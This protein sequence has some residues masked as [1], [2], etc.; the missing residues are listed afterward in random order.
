MKYRIL[1]PGVLAVFIL[2]SCN[3]NKPVPA[4]DIDMKAFFKN[5]EKDEF[6]ISPDGQYYSYLADYKGKSNVFV[7]NITSG[8]VSR[9]TNDT[10]RTIEGYFWKGSRI[11]Y[12]QDAMGDENFHFFSVKP[13]GADFK[14]LTPFAGVQARLLDEM[15]DVPGRE[16]DIVISLNKRDKEHPDPYLLNIETGE[17]T[18]LY[19]NRNNFY[20]WKTDNRGV[21]RIAVKS[22]GSNNSYYYRN[23]DRDT[24]SLLFEISFK[25]TFEP[26]YFDSTDKIIYARSNIGRDKIVLVEY[27]PVLRREVKVLY[28]NADYDLSA[29]DYDCITRKL[30]AVYWDDDKPGYHFF[31]PYW[32]NIQKTIDEKFPGYRASVTSYSDDRKKAIV[33]VYSTRLES[34]YYSYDI[35]NG[36]FAEVSNPYPWLDENNMAETR[37]ISYKTRDGLTVHGYLTIPKGVEAKNLPVVLHPHGGPHYRDVWG[38]DPEVKFLANKGYAVLQVNYR[39]SSGYGKKFY[40]SSFKQWGK[41]MQDDLTDGVRWLVKEGIADPKHV[42]IFGG[43]YGGYATLA[44]L[45]FTPNVYC[46]GVDFCGPSNLF[47][48]MKSFPPYWKPVLDQVYEQIGDPVKDS[49]LLVSASPALNVDRIKAPLFIAQGANDPRVNKGESDNMVDALKKRGVEVQYMVKNNEGHGFYNQDNL[50]DFYSAM[51]GFLDRHMKDN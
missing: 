10:I 15:K 45:T 20:G 35:A 18:L 23:N 6:M 24:F 31:D 43:S 9:V 1:F 12:Q 22:D 51:E 28:T 34:K 48:F 42:A 19:N 7:Q 17:L 13:D 49:L 37:P 40:E 2:Q 47:T 38:F 39:G 36:Q 50:F 33:N 26:D 11:I 32:G 8:N 16:G 4:P 41:A 30:K 27:D 14:E 25:E 29:T 44:G 21:V 3:T 5:G 46:C